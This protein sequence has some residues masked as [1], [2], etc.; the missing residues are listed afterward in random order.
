MFVKH[1]ERKIENGAWM[2]ARATSN[3][4]R[5]SEKSISIINNTLN[6]LFKQGLLNKFHSQEMKSIAILT[7]NLSAEIQQCIQNEKYF[8]D[9]Y[10]LHVNELPQMDLKIDMI[11]AFDFN[12]ETIFF[13]EISE[14]TNK[15]KVPKI[16]FEIA[17]QRI[18]MGPIFFTQKNP[19]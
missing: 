7:K 6:R 9:I 16:R 19:C 4:T 12:F 18:N 5:R 17:D 1:Q 14:K 15:Y 13:N 11:I 3:M 2:D 10:V 8:H